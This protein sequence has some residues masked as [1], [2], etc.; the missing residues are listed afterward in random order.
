MH[1]NI[2]YF[3]HTK[4][5]DIEDQ[6]LNIYRYQGKLDEKFK[7]IEAEGPLTSDKQAQ[8]ARHYQNIGDTQKSV[9]TL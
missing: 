1:L 7:D 9:D 6:I 8:I 2:H 3:K 4:D 5:H